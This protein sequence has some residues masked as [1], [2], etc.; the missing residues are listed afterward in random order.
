MMAR[1]K[2]STSKTNRIFFIFSPIVYDFKNVLVLMFLIEI[3]TVAFRYQC[4]CAIIQFC[5]CKTSHSGLWNARRYNIN[6]R[7][8]RKKVCLSCAICS[9]SIE[10]WRFPCLFDRCFKFGNFHK[11]LQN[12]FQAVILPD[13]DNFARSGMKTWI[14]LS[15]ENTFFLV[16][17]FF[18]FIIFKFVCI[19][20]IVH[21]NY[22]F[23]ENISFSRVLPIKS[24]YKLFWQKI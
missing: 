4:C 24:D 18:Y 19:Y 5:N 3:K 6:Y 14:K 2:N 1:L 7:M 23:T 12:F 11:S 15:L 21:S 22:D 17:K 16:L 13:K 10:W 8:S 9:Y 20:R